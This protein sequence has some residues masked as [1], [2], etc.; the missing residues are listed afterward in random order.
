MVSSKIGSTNLRRS[1]QDLIRIPTVKTVPRDIASDILKAY[2][3]GEQVYDSFKGERLERDPPAKKLH[4]PMKTNRLKTF[5][6]MCKKKDVKSSGRVTILKADIYLF[7]RIIV[8]A[9]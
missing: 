7:G 6:N 8:M 3:I 1:T 4:D 5:S 2:E 9:Q